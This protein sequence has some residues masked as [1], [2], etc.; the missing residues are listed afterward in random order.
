MVKN[1]SIRPY[2]LGGV[3]SG[4]QS[5]I[6]SKRAPVHSWIRGFIS[7]YTVIPYYS[8]DNL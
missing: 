3:A 5:K 4:V 2:F 7:G 8:W 6:C 1:P